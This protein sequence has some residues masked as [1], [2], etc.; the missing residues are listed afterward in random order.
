MRSLTWGLSFKTGIRRSPVPFVSFEAGWARPHPSDHC[1]THTS[2]SAPQPGSR[3]TAARVPCRKVLVPGPGEETEGPVHSRASR[4]D[5]RTQA[6]PGAWLPRRG[7]KWSRWPRAVAEG[8]TD[9]AGPCWETCARACTGATRQGWAHG[10]RTSELH[11][12]GAD[13]SLRQGTSEETPKGPPH[14]RV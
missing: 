14:L 4:C 9:L 11:P 10:A 6:A 7:Q 1:P 5:H 13:T 8:R 12:G 3:G 2:A